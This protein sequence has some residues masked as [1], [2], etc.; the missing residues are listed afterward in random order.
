[1]SYLLFAYNGTNK[2]G[3]IDDLEGNYET[4]EDAK[5]RF[6][7]TSILA[8]DHAYIYDSKTGETYSYDFKDM[9]VVKD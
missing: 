3:G 7:L 4:L 5:G 1:M 6:S 9:K 2:Q 8:K